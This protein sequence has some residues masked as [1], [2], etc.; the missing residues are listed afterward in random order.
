M[1][2]LD[3]SIR[4]IPGVGNV[5][6]ERLQRLGLAKVADL[7]NHF[8]TRYEDFSKLLPIAELRVGEQVTVRGTIQLVSSRRARHRRLTITEALVSDGTGTVKAVW[9]NQPYLSK[10]L[11]AGNTVLLAGKLTSSSYGLQLEHPTWEPESKSGL[12]TGRLVPQYPLTA[13]LTQH[14]LR[15]LVAR[16]LPCA[17]AITDWLPAEVLSETKI[18]PLVEAITTLHFPSSLTQ[19]R[20]A[21]QRV[22][23]N[24]LYLMHL[25]AKLARR[26]LGQSPA[27]AIPFA[28]QTKGFVAKLPW[29]LTRDQK[30]AA[31]QIIQDLGRTQPMFRLLQ[32][33]VGSGKTVVAGIA[34]LNAS[35][36]GFQTALLAPTEIL[37]H[38]HFTTLTKFFANGKTRLALLTR[39]HH[40]LTT[41]SRATAAALRHK[42]SQGAV[43]IVVG[44]HTLLQSS[45]TWQRLGLVVIDEQHRFGVEQRQMLTNGAG[46]TTPHLL[47]LSATPIPRSLA[48]TLF[49]DLDL[50][51]LASLPVGRQPITTTIVAPDDRNHVYNLIRI[52]IAQGNRAFIICPLIDEGDAG[53]V[54]AVTTERE[55]LA[56]EIFTDIPVGLLHGKMSSRDKVKAMND[57]KQGATPILVSTSVVEVGVDVPEA[58]VMAIENA[59]R[60][61]LA[62]LHQLRGRV[63][64]SHRPST[65]FLMLDDIKTQAQPRLQAFTRYNSGFALAEYDLKTRGPGDLLGQAQSGFL[66]LRFAELADAKLLELV[67]RSVQN[68]LAHDPELTQA[69]AL[70]AKVNE[71]SIHP[72]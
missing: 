15:A 12:H 54:Q 10:S 41:A 36:A 43:D 70:R 48:L 6:A 44:T 57:F 50:S 28:L 4:H 59:E 55:R 60:F 34:A 25:A 58:T 17:H 53:D 32:G 7:L 67:R 40:E 3:D 33:D 1:L 23:F 18:M 47:S 45:V 13:N 30:V 35:A 38:Q 37:A 46:G 21:R 61:G 62:Q 31:W 72:E 19:L 65:C 66:K 8:P 29:Q 27:P 52:E 5:T 56:K 68:T 14:Q 9:F 49:G 16:A 69:P 51:I 71:L 63:G 20:A 42:I 64:R 11:S 22:T 24:E 39:G 2:S 26:A